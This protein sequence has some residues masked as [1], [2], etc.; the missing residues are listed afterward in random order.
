MEEETNKEASEKDMLL[1]SVFEVFFETFEPATTSDADERMT[2]IEI[3]DH[4]ENVCGYEPAK[5]ELVQLL[6]DYAYSFAWTESGFK[7]LLKF[8]R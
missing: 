4:I 3:A 8:R 5:T 2:T 6:R 7:W 1:M